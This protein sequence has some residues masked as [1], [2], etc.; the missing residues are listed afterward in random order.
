MTLRFYKFE[1][2][3]YIDLPEWEG[4]VEDL[5]MVNGADTF[6]EIY[7]RKLNS[8]LLTF[9]IWTE[10]PD[11]PCAFVTKTDQDH[12]GATYQVHN[13]KLY[14]GSIWL[15]NVTKFVFGGNHPNSIY[16]RIIPNK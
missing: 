1:N 15:C 12:E 16:L 5:E 2:I 6:L 8:K 7:S 14:D 13:S 9:E 10:K 11:V 3:W 4:A